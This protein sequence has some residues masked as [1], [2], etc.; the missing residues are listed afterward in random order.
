MGLK[1]TPNGYLADT[2]I[3]LE[4]ER[5]R[6]SAADLAAIIGNAPVYGSPITI[7]ELA[8]MIAQ[9]G[10]DEAPAAAVSPDLA[11]LVEGLSAEEI[12]A[13]LRKLQL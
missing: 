6:L 2:G 5:G 8:Q 13:Q 9:A 7:A 10:G 11:E 3:W 1:K 12:E 4:V